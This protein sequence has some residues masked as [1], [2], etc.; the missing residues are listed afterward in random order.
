MSSRYCEH[1]VP[2][3]LSP[4]VECFWTIQPG[5]ALREYL[6][7][8]DGCVDILFSPSGSQKVQVVGTMTRARKFPLPEG[9]IGFGVRFRPAMS[10]AFLR[11]PGPHLMDQSIPLEDIWGAAGRQLSQQIAEANSNR[12]RIAL[13]EESLRH[14]GETGVVQ[15][16]C[17]LIIAQGGRVDIDK[18]AFQAGV[19]SRQLRRVF[20]EQT[21]LTPKHFSRVIRF[22]HSL[23]VLTSR[24]RGEWAQVALECG[25][26]DQAH[27]DN[28]FRELSGYSPSQFVV[29]ER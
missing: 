20:F 9:E 17:P 10:S 29:L 13:I 8:P 5:A 1:P 15:W 23:S 27:F 11:V 19:S 16:I 28:E 3:W 24:K 22:R 7:L 21:G 14:P 18:L 26:Y 4:Y 2:G 6:V 12:R 25:Y